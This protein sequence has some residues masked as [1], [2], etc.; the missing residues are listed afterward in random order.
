[1]FC[2]ALPGEGNNSLQKI[3]GITD[4]MTSITA[5]MKSGKE[6]WPVSKIRPKNIV[7]VIKSIAKN[8]ETKRTV[9]FS[10]YLRHK[11]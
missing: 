2:L 8:I 1:M 3:G 7:E 11:T 5:G 10:H 6:G 4:C 9:P